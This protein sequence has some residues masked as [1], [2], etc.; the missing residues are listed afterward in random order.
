MDMGFTRDHATDALLV[1]GNNLTAAMEWILSHPPAEDA[2]TS[3]ADAV[4]QPVRTIDVL[5]FCVLCYSC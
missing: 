4:S 3:E 2:T 5:M 1:C